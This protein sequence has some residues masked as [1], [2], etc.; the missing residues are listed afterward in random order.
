LRYT[1]KLRLEKEEKILKSAKNQ[2]KNQE[3]NQAAF[4]SN[5]LSRVKEKISLLLPLKLGEPNNKI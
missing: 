3:K 1:Q 2:E 4:Y 5:F